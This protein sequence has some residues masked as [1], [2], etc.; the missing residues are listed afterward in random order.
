MKK[1]FYLL[2]LLLCINT[3]FFAQ[4]SAVRIYSSAQ[5]VNTI[6]YDNPNTNA[7]PS[8]ISTIHS[9]SDLM[10]SGTNNVHLLT[11]PFSAT[12]YDG[13]GIDSTSAAFNAGTLAGLRDHDTLCLGNKPRVCSEDSI[14]I[15]A[16]GFQ[17][18]IP[19]IVESQIVVYWGRVLAVSNPQ[20]LDELKFATYRWYKDGVLLPQSSGD[21]IEIGNPIPAGKYG[22]S[23]MYSNQEFLYLERIFDR[24]FGAASVFPN[25]LSVGE[26][27]TV[28]T[29]NCAS[30]QTNIERIEILDVNG[31][32]QKNQIRK[33]AGVIVKAQHAVPLQIDGFKTRGTYFLRIL[34]DDHSVETLKIVV[35]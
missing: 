15:G 24:P 22:V 14:D 8:G 2:T 28:E 34:F 5:I 26:T 25:P 18:Y 27:L 30:L 6:I 12:L 23:V 35:K 16:Y 31:V 9:A 13:F 11:S 20:N 17:K 3:K 21:W 33:N 10:L 7:L 4:P 19:P 32:L 1:H 29:H